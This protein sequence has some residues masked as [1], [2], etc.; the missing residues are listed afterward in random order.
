MK[1]LLGFSIIVWQA[2]YY[3]HCNI[4]PCE[5]GGEKGYKG[6]VVFIVLLRTI[7]V[8]LRYYK[9]NIKCF[10]YVNEYKTTIFNFWMPILKDYKKYN[11]RP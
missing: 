6:K 3:Y 1:F 10:I 7:L 8:I 9:Q 2:Q 5:K 4:K 11:F